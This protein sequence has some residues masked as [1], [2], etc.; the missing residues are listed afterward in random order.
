LEIKKK[1]HWIKKVGL[2]VV[3]VSSDMDKEMLELL[4]LE[5]AT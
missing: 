3:V 1:K 2:H 4:P 5:N